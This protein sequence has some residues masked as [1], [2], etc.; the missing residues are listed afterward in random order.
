[1]GNVGP[2]T[3]FHGSVIDFELNPASQVSPIGSSLAMN[4]NE[5]NDRA[6]I[7]VD[8]GACNRQ[9]AYGKGKCMYCGKPLE[10]PFSVTGPDLALGDAVADGETPARESDQAAASTGIDFDLGDSL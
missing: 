2:L 1:M 6:K 5:A 4:T 10:L 7:K 3:L 8:C 9:V